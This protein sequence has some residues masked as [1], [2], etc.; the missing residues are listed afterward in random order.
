MHTSQDLTKLLHD[1][2]RD[3]LFCYFN[4][5][6]ADVI[7][8]FMNIKLD[9]N[10]I[11][12]NSDDLPEDVEY[13]FSYGGDGTFLDSVRLLNLR[14]IPILGINS[15]RLGFLANVTKN[16]LPTAI[17][18]LIGGQFSLQNRVLIEAK[19]EYVKAIRFPYA[20][21]EFSIQKGHVNMVDVEVYIDGEMVTTY[22]GDGVLVATPAGSTAY[23]LSVGGPIV[24]PTSSCFV[25]SPIAPH[26]LTMR[27][28]VIP[29]SAN[30]VFKV[31]SRD[32][33]N[34]MTIDNRR[35]SVPNGSEFSVS[36]AKSSIILVQLQNISF[37]QT[38]RNK[39]MWGLDTR[40]R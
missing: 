2:N 11:Y 38:L 27:P 17:N 22:R 14:N 9:A 24:S 33:E 16:E 29:D 39:M 26:N 21:N 37:Y 3:D 25:I 12:H 4:S 32:N 18:Y 10:Q 6:F 35:F 40:D 13:L 7:E 8:K 20:F 5:D 30:L 23:S 19:G 36:K 34:F 1:L 28:L 15:G 31:K